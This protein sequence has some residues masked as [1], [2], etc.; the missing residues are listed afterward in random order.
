MRFAVAKAFALAPLPQK[1]GVFVALVGR[2]RIFD[3]DVE[4]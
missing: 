2:S 3:G 4:E 1:F